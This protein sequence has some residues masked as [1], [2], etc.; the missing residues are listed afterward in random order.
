MKQE[1]AERPAGM[2]KKAVRARTVD[3]GG[4]R[5]KGRDCMPQGNAQL[6][7]KDLHLIGDQLTHEALANKKFE[8]YASQITDPALKTMAQTMAQH[9]KQQYDRLF[10]YLNSQN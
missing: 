10:T 7:Q 5:R 2:A 8:H 4:R 9:H 6:T 1:E 3:I